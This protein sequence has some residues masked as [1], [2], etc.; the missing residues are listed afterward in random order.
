MANSEFCFPFVSRFL[1][2][3]LSHS[4][5]PCVCAFCPPL[6]LYRLVTMGPLPTPPLLSLAHSFISP[7]SFSLDDVPISRPLGSLQQMPIKIFGDDGRIPALWD[8]KA[9]EQFHPVTP[10]DRCPSPCPATPLLFLL[11]FLFSCYV[12]LYYHFHLHIAIALAPVCPACRFKLR[13]HG[14][15]R[16]KTRDDVEGRSSYDVVIV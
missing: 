11:P 7:L 15:E 2:D 4:S 16:L 5:P 13:L 6:G 8:A 9:L 1:C 14:H 12:L 3:L 10:P